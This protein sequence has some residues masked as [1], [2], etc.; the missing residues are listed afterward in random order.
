MHLFRYISWP[1]HA[2][3]KVINITN[4]TYKL[5]SI[6]TKIINS[7]QVN[8]VS[9]PDR[10][11][12]LNKEELQKGTRLGFDTW[13][14]TSCS[15][16]HAYVKEFILG[17]SVTATGFSNSL[18]TLENLPLVHVMYAYD[19]QQGETIILENHNTIYM[20]DKMEDSLV[21]P[22]QCE[23]NGVQID[24]RSKKYYPEEPSA[25]CITFPHG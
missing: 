23:E 19:T 13:A 21:N 10:Y 2:L 3:R 15:G 6:Q 17:R 16:K 25:Q 18:G 14:D 8:K 11:P 5:H 20:S 4:Q 1:L 24:L 12:R 7:S 9:N 22:T